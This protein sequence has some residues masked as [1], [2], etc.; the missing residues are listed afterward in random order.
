MH[1]FGNNKINAA[2]AVMCPGGRLLKSYSHVVISTSASRMTVRSVKM[3]YNFS[4]EYFSDMSRGEFFVNL[5]LDK[6]HTF[7]YCYM[8]EKL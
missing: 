1:V 6:E 5:N 4:I 2:R 7:V 3:V 8:W